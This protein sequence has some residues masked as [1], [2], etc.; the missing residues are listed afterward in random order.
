MESIIT[1]KDRIAISLDYGLVRVYLREIFK[2]EVT[3][4]PIFLDF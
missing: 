3:Q 4:K 2:P 1:V